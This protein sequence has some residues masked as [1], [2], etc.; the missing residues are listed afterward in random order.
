MGKILMTL[1]LTLGETT[2][3]LILVPLLDKPNLKKKAINVENNQH[4]YR[5]VNVLLGITPLA[6]FIQNYMWGCSGVFSI[7]SHLTQFSLCF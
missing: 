7:S 4:Y 1:V 2:G 5:D 6:K 3:E